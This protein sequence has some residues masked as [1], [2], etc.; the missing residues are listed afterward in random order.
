VE[1]LNGRGSGYR[2][3]KVWHSGRGVRS[4]QV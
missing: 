4:L 3:S 2:P 1:G